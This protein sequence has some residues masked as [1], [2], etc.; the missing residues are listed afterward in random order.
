MLRAPKR[1]TFEVEEDVAVVGSRQEF[2]AVPE[3]ESRVGGRSQF[4]RG[5]ALRR[6]NPARLTC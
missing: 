5:M 3:D 6:D 1:M 4:G 2:E